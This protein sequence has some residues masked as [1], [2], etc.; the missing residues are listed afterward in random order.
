MII[1][2]AQ[3]E[4]ALLKDVKDASDAVNRL[5]TAPITQ[6]EFDALVDFVSTVG[7]VR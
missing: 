7:S 4:A 2:Q 6:D 3:A 5:V 1:T